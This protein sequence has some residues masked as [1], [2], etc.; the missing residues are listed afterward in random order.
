MK[1]TEKMKFEFPPTLAV[2]LR[3]QANQKTRGKL[4][5][6]G[7]DLM[8]QW[9]SGVTPPNRIISIWGLPELNLIEISRSEVLIGA[10]VTHARMARSPE[11]KRHLPAL[12]AAAATV[13][14]TQI[15]TRGTLGGNAA[16]ASPAGDTAPAL[17]VTGGW[18]VLASLAGVREVPLTEFWT[19]Y[20][21]IAARPDEIILAFRLPKKNKARERFRKIGARQAQA[22]SKV[23]CASRMLMDDGRIVSAAIAVGSVAPTPIRL[24][25]VE[26]YLAGKKLANPVIAKA[27]ALARAVEPI[28]DIRSTADYRRWATGRLVRDALEALKT[29]SRST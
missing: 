5:A 12:T 18:A 11:L 2:A 17:L 23:M 7:T 8:V 15:Q 14:A 25:A 28:S 16:N 20:R 21:Q 22:I 24:S 19:G 9:A 3:M 1:I 6:G 26:E 13:G 29:K 10:G 27:E 4:L